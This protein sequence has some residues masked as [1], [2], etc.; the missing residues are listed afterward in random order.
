[1][2]I[3]E[4]EDRIDA[5]VNARVIGI[6][7]RLVADPVSGVRDIVPTYRSVAVYFDPVRTSHDALMSRLQREAALDVP[8]AMPV[9]AAVGVPVCY[10]GEFGPD[11]GEVASFAGITE[12]EVVDLH[13][14]PTYRVFMLGFTPGLAYLGLVNDRI[15]APR[16]DSPR[17]RVPRGSVGIA[18]GQTGIYPAETPGGWQ[19]IGRTPVKPFDPARAQPFLLRPGDSVRFY[20]ID[21]AEF[22]RLAGGTA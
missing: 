7:A 16:R 21:R 10:G 6:A 12:P 15:A 2:L 1:V 14:S 17:V 3:V 5:A 4:L 13:A 18:G 22:D 8:K 20:P 11:L 19:I 9:A